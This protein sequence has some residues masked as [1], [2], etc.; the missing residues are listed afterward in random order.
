[1]AV[2]IEE[3]LTPTPREVQLPEDP[4][5][6]TFR[7]RLRD[8][9]A[10]AAPTTEAPLTTHRLVLRL[11]PDNDLSFG[12]P[13]AAGPLKQLEFDREIPRTSTT[14]RFVSTV[15]GSGA[16]LVSFEVTLDVPGTTGTSCLVD[17]L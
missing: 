5:P 7:V 1:M 6:I 10:P 8:N 11:E 15:H 2:I 12:P 13:T 16:G 17:L 14:F 9:R 4:V 3:D